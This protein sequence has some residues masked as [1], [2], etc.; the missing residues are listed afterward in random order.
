M[1]LLHHYSQPYSLNI[2]DSCEK[3][4]LVIVKD[5]LHFV[6]R[7]YDI[8]LDDIQIKTDT[9]IQ[10]SPVDNYNIKSNNYFKL[11]IYHTNNRYLGVVHLTSLTEKN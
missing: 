1:T 11:Y 8:D 6:K 9:T 3:A 10:I 4:T 7:E 5:T 2:S